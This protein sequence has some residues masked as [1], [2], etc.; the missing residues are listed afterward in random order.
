MDEATCGSDTDD[1]WK[2]QDEGA[3]SKVYTNIMQEVKL[4]RGRRREAFM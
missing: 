3:R 2:I 4:K 1:F